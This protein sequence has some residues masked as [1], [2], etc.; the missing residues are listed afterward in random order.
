MELSS[1][2]TNQTE[3]S[4][5]HGCPSVRDRA[6]TGRV[7]KSSTWPTRGAISLSVEGNENMLAPVRAGAQGRAGWNAV[8][9]T[10]WVSD[11]GTKAGLERKGNPDSNRK[12]SERG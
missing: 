1:T 10:G 11:N 9:E 5:L 6:R 4:Q 8:V 12:L 7:P 2:P 3:S